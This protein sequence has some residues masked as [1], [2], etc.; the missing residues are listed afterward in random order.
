[1]KRIL[2]LSLVLLISASVLFSCFVKH[3]HT[4][5]TKWSY[6][7]AGHWRAATCEHTD[8]QKSA[9]EHTDGDSDGKCDVCDYQMNGSGGNNSGGNSGNNSGSNSGEGDL[10][11]SPT[12]NVTLVAAEETSMIGKLRKHFYDNVTHVAPSIVTPDTPFGANL[13]IFGNIGYDIT[14]TAYKKLDRFVDSYTLAANGESAF[15]IYAEGG[16]LAVAYSDVYSAAAAINYIIDNMSSETYYANDVVASEVFN[17][18]DFMASE[19]EANREAT[20]AEIE[21]IIG[22]EATVALKS[23]YTLYG[24]ELYTWLAN[25]YD[26]ETGGFYYSAS[27]RD[28]EGFLPDLESTGQALAIIDNSGLGAG[29]GAVGHWGTDKGYWGRS[30]SER[31]IYVHEF[32][33]AEMW[34]Q[35][36]GFATSLKAADGYFYHP[37]W[38]TAIG[39]SR[40]G[41]DAGW[42][43]TL[44]AMYAKS[45]AVE[46]TSGA[47]LASYFAPAAPARSLS[48]RLGS[49]SVAQAVAQVMPVA[50]ASELQSK[51]SWY[52]YLDKG[53]ANGSWS[54]TNNLNSRTT[55]IRDA[56]LWDATIDYLIDHQ[57]D[58][59]LWENEITYESVSALMKVSSFFSSSR[60]NPKA[61][62]G[63]QSC[64]QMIEAPVDES[65]D[66][67]VFVYNP[68]VAINN[69]LGSATTEEQAEINA[70]LKD[71]TA[72]MFT[73]T[74]AKLS[75]F[76]KLDGGFSYKPNASAHLS[77]NVLVAIEGTAESDVNATTIAISS[78]LNNMLSVY[79]IS[80]NVPEL[81]YEYDSIYFLETLKN[82]QP[83]IKKPIKI[84]DPVNVDFEDFDSASANE[85]NGIVANPSP[86]SQMNLGS[87][88]MG[89]DGNYKFIFSQVIT[90][91]VE[92]EK[93]GKVLYVGDLVHDENENGKIDNDGMEC[94]A[95]GSNTEFK[96]LNYGLI[97]NTYVIDMDMYCLGSENF[98]YQDVDKDGNPVTKFNSSPVL[99][100]MFSQHGTSSHSVWLNFVP[101]EGD[102][103]KI[104]IRINE[105]FAGEDG[106]KSENIVRGIPLE[107]WF[108]LRVETYKIFDD[109]GTLSVKAKI[110]IDDVF[111]AESDSSH[112]S[113]GV[114]SD[115]TIN[116]VKLAYYRTCDSAFYFDN[117]YLY[118]SNEAYVPEQV[119]DFKVD[120]TVSAPSSYDFESGVTNGIYSAIYSTQKAADDRV[121]IEQTE[122]E[123][124]GAR[125]TGVDYGVFFSIVSDPAGSANKVLKINSKNT[126]S[127]VTGAIE[128]DV[129]KEE[130]KRVHVIEYDFYYVTNA[131]T[132]D[133]IQLELLDA[134]GIKNGGAVTITRSVSKT[135]FKLKNATAAQKFAKGQWYKI[136]IVID[137]D[138]KTIDFHFLNTEDGK[139]YFAAQTS[140]LGSGATISKIR[141]IINAYNNTGDVY[142]DNINYYTASVAPEAEIIVN[143][144]AGVVQPTSKTTYNFEGGIIPTSNYFKATSVFTVDGSL[145]TYDA[146]SAEY[147]AAIASNG[148]SGDAK[149]LKSAGVQYYVVTD[150]KNATNKVLQIVTRN[151]SGFTGT[152]DVIAS[153]TGTQN[154]VLEFTFDY[155]FDYNNYADVKYTSSLP[156]MRVMFWDGQYV[157][158][159]VAAER[160]LSVFAESGL[161]SVNKATFNFDA[162]KPEG[163]ETTQL[164]GS[165]K[166]GSLQV[167]SHAWYRIKIIV[168]G[169]KQYTYISDNGGKTYTQIGDAATYSADVTTMKYARLHIG[170][171]NNCSRQYVD[172]ISYE[173]KDTFDDPTK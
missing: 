44:I 125:P 27:A 108:N 119:E 2:A 163:Q 72:E 160:R 23:I 6:D 154:N 67:I 63:I 107:K 145:K 46:Q 85:A 157:P 128:L 50:T 101:Y 17:I 41:R 93:Y 94:P 24:S 137:S 52:T 127:A 45:T 97:G 103:G 38:G 139:Y 62:A 22:A 105:N 14:T 106:V 134:A 16:S 114:Y 43:N 124:D 29:L 138:A 147:A 59:G 56:G 95:N 75:V 65:L 66:A 159:D 86:S 172:N 129:Q 35:M 153:K 79:G 28:Y 37:Q 51:D 90:S 76:K 42:G 32:L 34:E 49:G 80:K 18:Q 136:R 143:E 102:D 152:V 118:K 96:F 26:P 162:T 165:L 1:M 98:Y 135:E 10:I 104:Y 54:I 74:R 60:P 13:I 111:V 87:E 36:N 84:E 31:H 130:G 133:M 112:S 7:E 53:F 92:P 117:V 113:G 20:F 68:W 55:E 78:I 158:E 77:Q 81:F 5:D 58:N 115:Y 161:S 167:N 126:S 173:M 99:Q 166:L 61:Y 142:M 131:H 88:E 141:M 171:Y 168:S 4:Y 140:T 109:E 170:G 132:A 21:K 73:M 123:I 82:L 110:F 15:L 91:P 121:T 156:M 64:I 71:H 11:W 39:S 69:T 89:M 47:A 25:L 122:V 151:G 149:L 48:A 83:V 19:R 169:G 155:Y 33:P 12:Q 3:E 144:M 40:R 9:G 100:L 70:Y 146:G 148:K 164:A 8:V 120:T 57:K 30:I 150:P 116:S